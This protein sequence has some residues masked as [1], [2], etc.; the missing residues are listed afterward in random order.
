MHTVILS[1]R[2]LAAQ[3]AQ[4]L[5]V[6]WSSASRGVKSLPASSAR[7]TTSDMPP[8]GAVLKS[9]ETWALLT[10]TSEDTC[11]LR[12]AVNIG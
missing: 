10:P 8:A 3:L 2:Q 11:Y 7:A 5:A 1:P 6:M 4:F 12:R 9:S